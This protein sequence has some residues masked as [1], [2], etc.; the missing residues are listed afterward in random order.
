M[1]KGTDSAA[2][3]LGFESWLH[4][5]LVIRPESITLPLPVSPLVKTGATVPATKGWCED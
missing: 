1:V 2:H 5:I 3:G 4:H